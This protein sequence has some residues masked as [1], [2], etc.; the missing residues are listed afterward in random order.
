MSPSPEKRRELPE[1]HVNDSP[2]DDEANTAFGGVEES[3]LGRFGGRWAMD[4][5]AETR[6]LSVQP[7]PR[8]LEG[9][10]GP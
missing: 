6:W 10:I 5:L 2:V 4:E 7:E 1:P 8:T 3:G 9:V